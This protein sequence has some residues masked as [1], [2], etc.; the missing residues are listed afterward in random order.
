MRDLPEEN[1][2]ENAQVIID[3]SKRLTSLV[4]DILDLS[5]LQQGQDKLNLERINLTQ[6]IKQVINRFAEF[7]KANGY[8]I[9]FIFNEDVFVE[10]DPLRISQAF[11]N[12]MINA[13]NYTGEDKKII[14]RQNLGGGNVKIEV[15]D[16]GEGVGEEELTHIWERYYSAK[17]NHVRAVAGS[18]IGLSIVKSI[19]ENHGGAYGV[20]SKKGEGACFWFSLKCAE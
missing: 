13:I 10:A 7:K 14:V 11:Y 18:G 2:P 5:K 3:E 17:T 9:E 8:S 16:T 12:L 1:N 6:E 19:I 4:K 15:A 20:V